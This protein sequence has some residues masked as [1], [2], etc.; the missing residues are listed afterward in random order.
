MS[1]GMKSERKRT[2]LPKKRPCAAV[3]EA[4]DQLAPFAFELLLV[5][6]ELRAERV[7]VE[8]VSVGADGVNDECC[9]GQQGQYISSH[10][11]RERDAHRRRCCILTHKQRIR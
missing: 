10:R 8:E 3:V 4:L 2:G 9:K 6:L 1:D 7:G 11:G 5:G